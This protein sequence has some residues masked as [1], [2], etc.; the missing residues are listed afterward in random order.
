MLSENQTS[1]G[2]E[3]IDFAVVLRGTLGHT[4]SEYSS[5]LYTPAVNGPARSE[6][7]VPSDAVTRASGLADSHQ[8]L[9]FGVNPTEGP[10]R[11]GQGRGGNDS[12]TRIAGLCADVDVK[13]GAC[14]T[15]DI[16]KAVVDE[17][18]ILLGSR[19]SVVI[20]SGGGLQPIWPI[21]DGD[22]LEAGRKVLDRWGRAVQAVANGRKI[23]LDNVSDAARV[24][25]VPGSYNH[26]Y[27]APRLV[28]A[29]ADIGRPLTIDE[30]REQ[31][32]ERGIS[33]QRDHGTDSSA[34]L[35]PPKD[36]K[37]AET[38]C[39]YVTAMIAGYTDDTPTGGRNPW[40]LSQRIR[41]MCAYRLGCITEADWQRA[42]ESLIE[43]FAEI[44]KDSR[45]GEPRQVKRL[46]HQDAHMCAVR[47]VVAKTNEEARKELGN[48][49]HLPQRRSRGDS[50]GADGE[51][52]GDE[53]DIGSASGDGSGSPM[54]LPPPTAPLEVAREIYKKWTLGDAL[55]L[56]H[57]RGDFVEWGTTQWAEAEAAAVEARIYTILG[58]AVYLREI[59]QKEGFSSEQEMPWNPN[60]NKV[61]DVLRAMAA[62]GHLHAATNTPTWLDN[63][64]ADETLVACDNGLLDLATRTLNEHSP[65]F[66][67][68]ISV[69]FDYQPDA[70]PPKQ[71]LNFLSTL[72]P[73]DQDSIALL[74]EFI[75][76]LLSGRTHMQKMLFLYGPKRSG[77]GTIARTLQ[78]LVGAGNYAAPTLANLATE[79]GLQ[80]LIGKSV[81]IIG[82]ARL[83][84]RNPTAVIERILSITGEDS[85]DVNRKFKDSWTGKLPTRLVLLSNELPQL[86]DASGAI[87]SRMLLLKMNKSFFGSED[88]ELEP[89]LEAELPAILNW[90]LDGLD[91]L[92]QRHRFTIPSAS[93][94]AVQ[95]LADLSS[96][97]SAFI[98]EECE[99]GRRDYLI[100][101]DDLFDAWKKWAEA[102]GH[103]A[104]DKG[105]FGRNLN[106][107]VDGLGEARID[108]YDETVYH[109]KRVRHWVGIRLRNDD[110]PQGVRTKPDRVQD[111]SPVSPGSEGSRPGYNRS[112]ERF[113]QDVQDDSD[114]LRREKSERRKDIQ[115]DLRTGVS[116]TSGTNRPDQAFDPGHEPGRNSTYPGREP[117]NP[118]RDPVQALIKPGSREEAAAYKAGLCTRCGVR[119]VQ[120]PSTRCGQCEGAS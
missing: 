62:V 74:Q 83:N 63:N 14:A 50:F 52:S 107:A 82:D 10:A 60:R 101:K 65:H 54:V 68:L 103:K 19:P 43:R 21:A 59:K 5:L 7:L 115:A 6:V 23:K 2:L 26:K 73:D 109:S 102:A 12:V 57:W 114:P 40:M 108:V 67:N 100:S 76:Y 22:N 30:I 104:G 78:K 27:G 66:F 111:K 25:R 55:T 113:V 38:T 35:S 99:I 72:W 93:D 44:V 42:D 41:L 51:T 33:E 64:R 58:D 37:W 11:K 77:K 96:P 8:A 116:W 29:V 85:L 94:E 92:N 61:A 32:D 80:S 20:Y 90:A 47:K 105:V 45:Y 46:E 106:A 81:A 120:P 31:L 119:R 36:W 110:P 1:G 70:P 89:K 53:R 97:I 112:S 84:P 71:W 24:L 79:F 18:S 75:G 88:L 9:W 117:S 28:T 34:P 13:K 17:L 4:G 39:P 49:Q 86:E 48:H 118:G 95:M 69:P 98:R 56:R 91:R 15:L 16:A 87:A 3:C